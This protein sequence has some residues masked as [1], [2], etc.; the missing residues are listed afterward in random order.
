MDIIRLMENVPYLSVT[1]KALGLSGLDAYLKRRTEGVGF[2]APLDSFYAGFDRMF[3]FLELGKS[4]ERMRRF[5]MQLIIDDALTFIKDKDAR[6]YTK[7]GRRYSYSQTSK[8]S[9]SLLL[10]EGVFNFEVVT[11]I[12]VNDMVLFLVKDYKKENGKII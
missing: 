10:W 3:H 6:L 5:F 4:E 8:T 12:T 11:Y 1:R 7:T 2:I 9:A